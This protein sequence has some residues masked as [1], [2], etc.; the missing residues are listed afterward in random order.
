MRYHIFEPIAATDKL[1]HLFNAYA[2]GLSTYEIITL[3][4]ETM[5]EYRRLMTGELD[6]QADASFPIIDRSV[7]YYELTVLNN[8]LHGLHRHVVQALGILE[9]FFTAYEGEL[10]RF[11]IENRISVLE[12][13]GGGEDD[14]WIWDGIGAKS[15][16]AS[17]KASYKD[18]AESLRPYSLHAELTYYFDGGDGREEYI[19]TS[20]PADFTLLSQVVE[21]QTD[22]SFRK[23]MTQLGSELP[24]YRVEADGDLKP[25]SLADQIEG[26]INED[27]ANERLVKDF[28]GVLELGQQAAQLYRI[29]PVDVVSGY[30][31]LRMLLTHMLDV[32]VPG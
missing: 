10:T 2:R 12:E 7:R 4:R 13:D 8:T 25:L 11:A 23:L 5:H 14:D 17:W 29:L 9:N 6:Q 22:L 24:V 16:G 32:I 30:Q 15:D 21:M 27:L 31:Q 28:N 20:T 26:E 18:D 3:P 19:G 1:A